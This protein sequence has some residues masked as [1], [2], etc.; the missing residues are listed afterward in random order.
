MSSLLNPCNCQ[1]TGR[2]RCCAPKRSGRDLLQEHA[3]TKSPNGD[4]NQV[5]DSLIEMFKAK[6][7]TRS[8]GGSTSSGSTTPTSSFNR[9]ANL[10]MTSAKLA[11]PDNRHHPAHTSPHVHKV[12]L[13]S[14][15]SNGTSSPRPGKQ[16]SESISSQ[17]SS[18]GVRPPPPR[19]RPLSDMNTFLGA[20]FKEDGSVASEIP[21]SALGLPGIASFDKAAMNGGVKVEPMAMDTDLPVSFP[22]SEDVVIGACTCGDGCE[23]PNCATHGNRSSTSP[24][25][26]DHHHHDGGCG[27]NCTS[28]FDCAN[29]LSIPSGVTSIEHLIQIAAANVPSNPSRSTRRDLNPLDTGVLPPAAHMSEDAAQAFGIVQLRPLECCN[30]RCQCKPG[31][32][33]CESDCCGCCESCNCGDDGDT[34]MGDSSAPAAG[35]CCGSGNNDTVSSSVANSPSNASASSSL[36]HRQPSPAPPITAGCHSN[37]RRTS[38]VSRA[39][40]VGDDRRS[41]LGDRSGVGIQRSTSLGSKTAAKTPMAL[42][43]TLHPRPILPKP[44]SSGSCGKGSAD[45]LAPPRS[46]SAGSRQPSPVHRGSFSSSQASCCSSPTTAPANVQTPTDVSPLP[47]A[48]TSSEDALGDDASGGMSVGVNEIANAL[49]ASDVDFM[50]Y[51]NSLLPATNE[52]GD[53]PQQQQQQPQQHQQQPQQQQPQQHTQQQHQS[54]DHETPQQS[55]SSTTEPPAGS[56]MTSPTDITMFSHPSPRGPHTEQHSIGDIQSMIAGALAQQGMIPRPDTHGEQQVH[57]Y[58]YLFNMQGSG[59]HHPMQHSA[60]NAGDA[61]NLYFNFNAGAPG[62]S[63]HQPNA[64]SGMPV[65]QPAHASHASDP[66]GQNPQAFFKPDANL[67]YSNYGAGFPP[68][69]Q[70]LQ[71]SQGSSHTQQLPQLTPQSV[72]SAVAAVAAGSHQQQHHPGMPANPDII[73]LSKPLNPT[74]VDR[75]LQALLN[76]Q[77]RQQGVGDAVATGAVE[78]PPVP[79]VPVP[80]PLQHTPSQSSS[81]QTTVP[82]PAVSAPAVPNEV[83]DVFSTEYLDRAW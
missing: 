54:S 33:K 83:F 64:L 27:S 55:T 77:A 69:V 68:S 42:S 72:A 39:K 31:E 70:M 75:I 63:S 6:A 20:V 16:R 3:R 53:Q 7:T 28:G 29:H 56:H 12:R 35:G 8:D 65:P 76:Q 74:D 40:E 34:V 23:C 57:D 48:A 44:S 41:S 21:R 26:G 61:G 1:T 45:R 73:D 79:N 66:S 62:P 4:S 47:P 24:P 78:P 14:P 37:V 50:S 32:C 80:P 22:T 25:N 5:T 15:Y 18:R 43:Q 71:A 2:C 60:P 11:S 38:S 13:Y 82:D 59:S 30:G 81:R 36:S 67:Y 10:S 51:L 58:G 52:G 17:S 49:A 9:L 19:I 46:C